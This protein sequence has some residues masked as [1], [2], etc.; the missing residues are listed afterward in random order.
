MDA[1]AGEKTEV[2]YVLRPSLGLENANPAVA[3]LTS[4]G[5]HKGLLFFHQPLRP[6]CASF[7]NSITNCVFE[8]ICNCYQGAVGRI[9]CR[10]MRVNSQRAPP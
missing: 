9:R 3:A 4:G 6:L 1:T 8:I 7:S 5:V 10:R 2:L